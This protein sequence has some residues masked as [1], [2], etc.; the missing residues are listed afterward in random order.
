MYIILLLYLYVFRK[1]KALFFKH[2]QPIYAK[3]ASLK[4]SKWTGMLIPLFAMANK[5]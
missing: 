5:L 4:Y 1:L 3:T 2:L